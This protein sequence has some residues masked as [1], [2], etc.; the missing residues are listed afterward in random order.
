VR[1]PPPNWSWQLTWSAH[2]FCA[3][4]QRNSIVI[5]LFINIGYNCYHVPSQLLTN[6]ESCLVRI[7]FG[8]MSRSFLQ[9]WWSVTYSRI[10]CRLWK[11][12]VDI[13]ED[14]AAGNCRNLVESSPHPQ[15]LLISILIL[16]ITFQTKILSSYII[17]AVRAACNLLTCLIRSPW[18][19][20]DYILENLEYLRPIPPVTFI[21]SS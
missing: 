8:L 5:N 17:F 12:V 15:I 6:L 3:L 7:P 20:K 14:R 18:C 21:M 4:Y 9:S 11:P 19:G 1:P 13:W 16:S 10:P 2:C